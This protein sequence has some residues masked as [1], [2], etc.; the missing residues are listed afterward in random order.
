MK[1]GKRKRVQASFTLEAAVIVP[2]SLLLTAALLT[3]AFS[4]HDRVIMHTVSTFEVM[5]RAD[6]Y[7][8]APLSVTEEVARMLDARLISAKEVTITEEEKEDGAAIKVSAQAESPLAAIQNLTQAEGF[9][10]M[11]TEVSHLDGRA[12]LIRY[13]TICDGLAAL[14]SAEKQEGESTAAPETALQEE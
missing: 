10:Q 2:L 5:Q 14:G 4:L 3:T 6:A 1:Q 9:L 12:A 7:R 11:Q 8:T 13:K